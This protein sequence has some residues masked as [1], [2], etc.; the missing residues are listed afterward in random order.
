MKN[1]AD[2]ILILDNVLSENDCIKLIDFYKKAGYYKQHRDT[3]FLP[4]TSDMEISYHVS[5]IV[6]AYNDFSKYK[7]DIGWCEIVE[8]PENSYQSE[9]LDMGDPDTSF[10][11]ITYLNNTYEGGK[12][13]FVDD[14]EIIPK[15]G[16]TVYFDGLH[17]RHGV[18]QI[19][20][21]VRYT[22]PIWYNR[23]IS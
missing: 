20:N 23:I 2:K 17:Y 14:I 6:S 21:G 5:K 7:I 1:F 12:T 15:V 16:R 9:H 22:L 18:T 10:A 8:W 19:K 13:F 11:S 4:L 3:F